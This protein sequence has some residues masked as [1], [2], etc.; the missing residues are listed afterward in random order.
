MSVKYT[1]AS[2]SGILRLH[3]HHAAV[4][5]FTLIISKQLPDLSLDVTLN[6]DTL[7]KKSQQ[8]C[9]EKL[10]H[11]RPR[12]WYGLPSYIMLHYKCIQNTW[13]QCTHRRTI[14]SD[15]DVTHET[16]FSPCLDAH[17]NK[18]LTNSVFHIVTYPHFQI[19]LTFTYFD[20]RLN[21]NECPFHSVKVF[22]FAM[23]FF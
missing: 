3:H 12:H 19:N 17:Y 6:V 20:L 21:L 4:T 7:L 22:V 14:L 8:L 2:S 13:S 9:H 11:G 16:S 5:S 10:V 23:Y 1:G 15:T 18:Y